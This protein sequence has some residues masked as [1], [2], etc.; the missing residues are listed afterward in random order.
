MR[1]AVFFYYMKM[2]FRYIILNL[3]IKIADIK[4]R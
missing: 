1:F 3:E 2:T 4:K